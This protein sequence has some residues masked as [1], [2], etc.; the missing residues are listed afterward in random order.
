MKY[1]KPNFASFTFHEMTP[2]WCN[3]EVADDFF[4]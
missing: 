4:W 1:A 2:I 3:Q